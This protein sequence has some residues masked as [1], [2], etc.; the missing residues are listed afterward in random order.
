MREKYIIF[1]NFLVIIEGGRFKR[2][3]QNNMISLYL[4]VHRFIQEFVKPSIFLSDILHAEIKFDCYPN[5]FTML[6]Y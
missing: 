3:K 6:K 5:D 2:G 4:S 1:G